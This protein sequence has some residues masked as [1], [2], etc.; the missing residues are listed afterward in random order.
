[1]VWPPEGHDPVKAARQA[2]DSMRGMVKWVAMVVLALVAILGVQSTYYTV[3][4]EEEAV[5]LRLG[6]WLKTS[7]PGLHFRLPL[8]IDQV[9]KIPVRR[10]LEEEFGFRGDAVASRS[11]GRTERSYDAEARMLTGDLNVADVEWVVQFQISDPMKYL[12]NGRN[13]QLGSG[14]PV[15]NVRDI[16]LTVMR[17]VVG[18]R[19]VTEVLTVGRTEI[20]AEAKRLTQKVLDRYDM[21]IRIVAVKLQDVNPPD[22]VKPS[23]NDVNTAKQEQEQV[24]NQAEREYN[25]VIPEARGKAQELISNAEGYAA[26]AV[27]RA[28]GDAD[29]FT[30]KLMAYREAPDVTRQRLYLEAMEDLYSRIEAVTIVDSELEGLLP[31]FDA[32]SAL[33]GAPR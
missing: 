24:I 6:K 4:P 16:S 10:V 2:L 19:L 33:G 25:K 11:R 5:I 14:L 31:I 15:A 13:P 27:N 18:D 28:Q 26:A 20:A 29:K 8:G 9:I 22:P 1:M 32:G 7:G 21:G 12:F 17:R 3:E 30:L 23:F